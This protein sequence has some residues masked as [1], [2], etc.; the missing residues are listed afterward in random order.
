M[1][2]VYCFANDSMPGLLKIGMTERTP[3]ERLD[4]A[5][6]SDTWRPPTPYN[7]VISK[8]VNEPRKKEKILHEIL[9]EYRVKLNREFFRVSVEKIFPLFDLMDGEYP[10]KETNNSV[11]FELKD[12]KYPNTK[13]EVNISVIF[14]Q[15][16]S[17]YIDIKSDSK[18]REYELYEVFSDWYRLMHGKKIPKVKELFDYIK[19][20]YSETPNVVKYLNSWNGLTIIKEIDDTF[21]LL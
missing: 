7:I 14:E 9:K 21:D 4:E 5:N 16:T 6:A 10:N 20:K 13:Q 15:F 19:M 17:K 11:I 1:G 12:I 18:I 2:Y 3:E 8:K